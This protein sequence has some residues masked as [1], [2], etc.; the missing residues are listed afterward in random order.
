MQPQT[1]TSPEKC[2]V[3]DKHHT[4]RREKKMKVI[5]NRD[6]RRFFTLEDMDRAKMVINIEKDDLETA[7]GWAELALNEA[8]RN[9]G[10]YVREVLKATAETAKNCRAWNVYAEGTE[11]M[12]IWVEA[13]AETANGFVKIGAYLSDIWQTGAVPYI[14][15]MFIKY[16]KAAE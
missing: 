4:K 15:H 1:V 11:D 9:K 3:K 6:C 14:G 10:D 7:K 12:D 16:Y 5:M 13:T 8:L 2:R